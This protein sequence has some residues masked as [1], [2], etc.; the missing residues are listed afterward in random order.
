LSTLHALHLTISS[1][2]MQDEHMLNYFI[3]NNILKP[4][5]DAFVANGN[6]YNL[7]NSAVLELFEYIR[8]VLN[9]DDYSFFYLKFPN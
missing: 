1:F 3:K 4:I 7:L 2:N 9:F 8:K 6:R 5:I